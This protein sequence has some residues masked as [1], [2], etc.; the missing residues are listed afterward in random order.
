[1]FHENDTSLALL[2]TSE[3]HFYL[4]VARKFEQ[5][6]AKFLKIPKDLH[7]CNLKISK[8]LRQK[9]P[10]IRKFLHKSF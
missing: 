4:I 9:P 8:D 5:K 10:K 7:L 2:V 3:K 1:M 6:S